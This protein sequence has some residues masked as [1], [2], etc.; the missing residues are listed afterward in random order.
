MGRT[1]AFRTAPRRA[2]QNRFWAHSGVQELRWGP[3]HPPIHIQGYYAITQPRTGAG[4]ANI[5]NRLL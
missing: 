1:R 2:D 3:I 4:V 5:G